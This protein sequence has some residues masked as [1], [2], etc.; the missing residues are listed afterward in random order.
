VKTKTRSFQVVYR[1]RKL[2][3]RPAQ[4]VHRRAVL[5]TLQPKGA[6]A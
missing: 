2:I 5:S 6:G 1:R 3:N 4:P